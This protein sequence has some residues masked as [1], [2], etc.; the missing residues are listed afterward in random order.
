MAAGE[1]ASTAAVTATATGA[2]VAAADGSATVAASASGAAGAGTVVE[3][4]GTVACLV[5][6]LGQ[7]AMVV[8][9]ALPPGGGGGGFLP[10]NYHQKP[11]RK[12]KAKPAKPLVAATE[13]VDLDVIRAVVAFLGHL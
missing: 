11:E 4:T 7:A 10:W 13:E 3:A 9:P 12:P 6:A 5:V 8:T 1:G 2:A